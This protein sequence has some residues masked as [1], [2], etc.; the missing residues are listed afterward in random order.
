MNKTLIVLLG[1]TGVGKTDLSIDIASF[2][3]TSIISC[4][5]RQIY[6]EMKIGTAVPSEEQ[7]KRVPHFFVGTLSVKE[8]YNSWQFE[9]QALERIRLL[10]KERD[11]VVMAGGSMMYIDAVCKGIDDIPTIA[12]ELR[13]NLM[14][15]YEEEGLEAI[16]RQLK[17]L[18][19]VFYGQVDLNNAKRV[20]H[21]VEVCLMAGV[22]YS[23]LRTNAPKDRGFRIL[24]IGLMRD[25][26]ELYERINR[27]VDVML[28][29]GLMDEAH[30]LYKHKGLNA[31][32]T[33]G[34]K[35][36]FDFFDGKIDREEAVRL[37]KRNSRRYAKKQL[38]WFRRDNEIQ[39]FHP[40]EKEKILTYIQTQIQ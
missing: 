13:Q 1:P 3:D 35:E 31:L 26:E 9:Q 39:W 16:C 21:A 12:P 29:E 19:P 22:P 38:S 25:K 6:K 23:S 10:H 33:V 5:S 20:L 17:Q 32:N 40:E 15:R 8:Y 36:C 37:I 27:R 34:Y 18:D 24:K 14:K 2:F 7:L 4:D 28:E 30:R 11:I